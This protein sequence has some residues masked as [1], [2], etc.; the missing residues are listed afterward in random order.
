MTRFSFFFSD[1]RH[2]NILLLMAVYDST[3]P[4]KRGLVLEP[5]ERGFLRTLLLEDKTVFDEDT[6][7]RFSRDVACAMQFVQQR[8]YIHCYLGSP[9]VVLTENFT[10][11]V[12]FLVAHLLRLTLSTLQIISDC[13]C[14]PQS[15]SPSYKTRRF[16]NMKGKKLA[17][18]TLFFFDG[19]VTLLAG[20]TLQHVRSISN[21]VLPAG[22]TR[23]R[24]DNRELKQ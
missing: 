24:R 5:V 14:G 9:S 6:V 7:L 22:S 3:D 16:V 10:A 11:K 23:S 8:G 2:P 18:V 19:R 13:I 12:R 17:R 21:L 15:S 20:P 1:L 4:L